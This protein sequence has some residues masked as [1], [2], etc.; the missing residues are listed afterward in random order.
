VKSDRAL[1]VDCPQRRRIH[2]KENCWGPGDRRGFHVQRHKRGLAI[3]LVDQ[4]LEFI[5]RLS[6]CVLIIQK[7]RIT[8]PARARR[9]GRRR[10]GS[11]AHRHEPIIEGHITTTSRVSIGLSFTQMP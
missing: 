11:G 6:D 7:G 5:R 9:S 8:G 1:H 2:F 4:N 3:V 10:S